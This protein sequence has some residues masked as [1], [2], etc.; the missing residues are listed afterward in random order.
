MCAGEER[1]RRECRGAELAQ[2]SE[3]CY[4][5]IF[6]AG[7]ACQWSFNRIRRSALNCPFTEPSSNVHVLA[8]VPLSTHVKHKLS[9]PSR[10]STKA[11]TPRGYY[12]KPQG[13]LHSLVASANST[14]PAKIGTG[15][16][17]L[18]VAGDAMK[19]GRSVDHGFRLRCC[20]SIYVLCRYCV[21]QS[22]LAHTEKHR[23]KEVHRTPPSALIYLLL[24]LPIPIPHPRT[25][26]SRTEPSILRLEIKKKLAHPHV[27]IT[28]IFQSF[29]CVRVVIS[30]YDE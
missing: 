11:R 21:L 4:L 15:T 22:R 29:P 30:P 18:A 19:R 26:S 25:H 13:H 8:D 14:S 23:Q 12:T 9:I 27:S 3:K 1:A 10:G 7:N 24:P 17:G 16:I 5:S 28:R 6:T 2:R 20:V